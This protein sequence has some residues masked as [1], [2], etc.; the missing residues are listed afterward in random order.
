SLNS[1]Q[2]NASRVVGPAI[3]SVLFAQVGASWVFL[4]NALSYAAV[5]ATLTRVALPDPPA[6][7]TQGLHRLLEGIAYA[8]R[9]RAVG[10]ALLVIFTF[11]FLSLPFITQ[12]PTLADENL[13]IA[14][15]S[16]AYG[17][18]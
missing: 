10:Q 12:L 1:V 18:L 13:G 3:G 17:L 8:R 14:A 6:S 2:M 16:E 9:H 11:S 4:L 5:I 15:R 7:G